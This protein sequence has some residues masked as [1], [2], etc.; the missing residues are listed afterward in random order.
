MS[1][2]RIDPGSK[3]CLLDE[4]I[5]AQKRGEARGI[6]SVCSAHPSVMEAALVHARQNDWPVLIE[7]TSNQVDQ[8]GGYTGMT[9]AAFY[10]FVC[11]MADRLQF[12]R[13]RLIIGGDH[14]GPNRWQ[15]E[16]AGEA[17]A[18]A[19]VLVRDCVRAGYVKIHLD[20]SMK[21]ADDPRQMPLDTAT[22]AQRAAE[23]AQAAEEAHRQTG[24]ERLAPRYVIGTEVPSPG[25]IRET[26]EH[27]AVTRVSDAAETIEMTR[28]AFVRA[29][30]EDAWERVMAV[31]VQPGV[32]YGNDAIHEYNPDRAADL[33][34]FIE[35]HSNL[36]YEAHSTDYQTRLAL[37]RLVADHFA[38]LKVGPALTFAYREAIFA[39]A[40]VEEE[41]LAECEEARLSNVRAALE[42]AMV[43][44]PAHWEGYYPGGE[45]A[46]H[47]A[48]KYSFSD[49]SRYYWPH[50]NVQAALARLF[51]NLEAQPLPLSLL[52]QF[53]P[54]QYG[55]I[56][57]G[58]LDSA[59]K[60]LVAD[61]I[62]AILSDY[63]YACGYSQGRGS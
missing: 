28:D 16:S 37:R 60:A 56:K 45:A 59:P 49:R 47:L 51:E 10:E 43:D 11:G 54:E 44:D 31:V 57:D 6:C 5:R 14:L 53:L 48:R 36:V 25:G 63:A 20:A 29:G 52:S 40:M 41:L 17:M 50:P 55:R 3:S 38:I 1:R 34:R 32:E 15:K 24:A 18:R 30:L 12:P 2:A 61:K 21:C 27:L 58:A 33:S 8:Y 13:E 19:C 62:G 9:P 39:L 22:V 46:Q 35:G 7:S 4:I 42:K 26:G 23:L